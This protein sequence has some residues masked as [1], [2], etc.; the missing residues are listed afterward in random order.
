[1]FII[2]RPENVSKDGVGALDKD[3][4]LNWDL[5]YKRH[6][7]QFFR[8]RHYLHKELPALLSARSILEVGCG[9]GNTVYP[10]LDLCPP[11]TRLWA[12]D[13][14]PT[15][16]DLVKAN[17]AYDAARLTAF[18]ADLTCDALEQNVP[19]GSI[20]F[21]TLVFVLSAI[22]PDK[23]S[24]AIRNIGSVLVAGAGRV[25]LRDYCA[26][27]LAEERLHRPGRTR[28]LSRRAYCRSDGTR[29]YFFTEEEVVA[30]FASEGF[31]CDWVN[32]ERRTIVNR[33]SGS[34]MQRR[35]IQACFTYTPSRKPLLPPP[36]PP[37]TH[38]GAPHAGAAS[39]KSLSHTAN[40][41]GGTPG[42][43][44]ATFAAAAEDEYLGLWGSSC[45]QPPKAAAAVSGTG[46]KRDGVGAAASPRLSNM[47]Q[48]RK[49]GQTG[50]ESGDGFEWDDDGAGGVVG[51]DVA[52]L[53]LEPVE[54]QESCVE[55][56]EG[57]S[58]QLRL[59]ERHHSHT[60]SHTGL[61]LWAAAG[62][63][64]HLILRCPR[65][66]Q[67]A[68]VLEMGSG[69]A[70]LPAVAATRS[71]RAVVATDGSGE[72]LNLLST[73]L[74]ANSSRF[75]AERLRLRRLAW[76]DALHIAELQ[77]EIPHGFDAI[78]GADIVYATE[79]LAALFATAAALLR[80]VPEAFVLLCFAVRSVAEDHVISVAATEGFLR[81]PLPSE[82]VIA[83]SMLTPPISE[84]SVM[85][86]LLFRRPC[87]S[88]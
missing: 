29:T 46:N 83:N 24:A 10:L 4:A 37:A 39:V 31:S 30:M 84:T 23:F 12:C 8:D 9:V 70:A 25:Y 66:F 51:S 74:A 56:Q 69:A 73:N 7:T 42:L 81:M 62:P 79:H 40:G 3:A 67:W 76:G 50:P 85:R 58:L 6:A 45:A 16:V 68:T 26:G 55:L 63:L 2:D 15:A 48:A 64:A 13:F 35:W 14:S 88:V 11:S 22:A 54:T 32:T 43:L 60:H 5:F 21:C 36:G 75:F 61:L 72:T 80:P 18:T 28:R 86:F 78:I 71:A 59:V 65:T 49:V 87:A 52:A 77:E 53:F 41:T 33:G 82:I 27:D 1:M 17:T 44:E 47:H 20:E 19:R 38:P 34:T 57:L